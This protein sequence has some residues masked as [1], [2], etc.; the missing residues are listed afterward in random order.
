MKHINA[1]NIQNELSNPDKFVE[2]E[3]NCQFVGYVCIRDPPRDEVKDSINDCRTAGV[4]VIM[5]TGDAKETAIA[6]A[7]ELNILSPSQKAE[8]SCWTGSEFEK[9]SAREKNLALKGRQGKVFC[10]VEPR[11]KRELVKILID[12]VSQ[13]FSLGVS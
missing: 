1:S 10:R 12:M 3:S 6:I 11:H 9:L 2:L 4:N 7:R 8:N 5:I 13:F